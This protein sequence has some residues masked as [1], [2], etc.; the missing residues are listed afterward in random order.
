MPEFFQGLWPREWKPLV[1]I[2][3][4]IPGNSTP[5]KMWHVLVS[6]SAYQDVNDKEK[7][8]IEAQREQGHYFRGAATKSK[9]NQRKQENAP[10]S[11]GLGAAFSLPEHS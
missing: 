7:Q 4:F 5:P 9:A 1:W 3:M 11:Q 8:L 10:G 6:F 2:I